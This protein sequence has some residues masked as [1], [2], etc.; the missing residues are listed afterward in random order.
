MLM[1]MTLNELRSVWTVGQ[2][3]FSISR[4]AEVLHASQPGISRHVIEVEDHLGVMLFAR[5]KNRLVGPTP[6]GEVLLPLIGRI[7]NDVDDLKRIAKQ[8]ATGESGSLSVATSHTH[9]RYVLPSIIKTFIGEFPKA[10]LRIRQGHVNQIAEWVDS[11][12]AD[13]SISAAPNESFPDLALHRFDQIRRIVL[14]PEGHPLLAV[15][16]PSLHDIAAWPI[17]TYEQQFVAYADIMGA[18]RK[19][20]LEPR[21]VLSTGDTDV[22]KMYVLGGLGVAILAG[23]AFDPRVDRGLAEVNVRRLFPLTPLYIGVKKGRPLSAQALRFIE[24]VAPNLSLHQL[25]KSSSR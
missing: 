6:A 3:G 23:Q 8:H 13:V 24:L 20:R 7:L 21:V 16:R 14:A 1:R 17:I 10:D 2:T 18:F 25:V 11:G 5:R 9:A 12:E 4:T 22:M 15:Q 19:A